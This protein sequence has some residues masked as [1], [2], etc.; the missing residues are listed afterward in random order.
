MS[1]NFEF[2]QRIERENR[3][4]QA[5]VEEHN[6][7][8][9]AEQAARDAATRAAYAQQQAA[10]QQRIQQQAQFNAMYKPYQSPTPFF[11]SITG[12]ASNTS[13]LRR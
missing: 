6:R 2:L 13:W 5:Q 12:S 3:A 1:G 4:R 11:D 8:M 10:E 7:R 9:A